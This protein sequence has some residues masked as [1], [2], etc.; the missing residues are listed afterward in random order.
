[1]KSVVISLI[2]YAL[3]HKTAGVLDDIETKCK[4][5][6]PYLWMLCMQRK[7]DERLPWPETLN[8]L[9]AVIR[10]IFIF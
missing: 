4:Q 8:Q 1:M 2:K 7:L 10:Q 5:L 3:S 6:S 9:T